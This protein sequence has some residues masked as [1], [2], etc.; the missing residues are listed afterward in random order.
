M[1]GNNSLNNP[2][3]RLNAVRC[4]LEQG[5]TLADQVSAVKMQ[6]QVLNSRAYSIPSSSAMSGVNVQ[7]SPAQ[8]APF[9]EPVEKRSD[10][11]EKLHQTIQLL[12]ALQDQMISVINR[13]TVGLENLILT[14][15][16]ISGMKWE[17]IGKEVHLCARQVKRNC[18]K[19]MSRIILPEDAI[20]FT[21][22]F[23]ADDHSDP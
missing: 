1:N 4:Y 15:H 10:L 3:D 6:L 8:E 18:E 22:H 2:E 12:H 7:T 21:F 20:W 14:F 16:Y 13:Y 17:E 5:L 11:E 23:P 9:E 19:A